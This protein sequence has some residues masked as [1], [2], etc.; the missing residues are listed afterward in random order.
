[1]TKSSR[2]IVTANTETNEYSFPIPNHSAQLESRFG[3]ID[4]VCFTLHILLTDYQSCRE[5]QSYNSSMCFYTQPVQGQ[6]WSGEAYLP[7]MVGYKL[8][9]KTP[10]GLS[11]GKLLILMETTVETVQNFQTKLYRDIEFAE[12]HI[13]K[14]ERK[15]SLLVLSLSFAIGCLCLLMCTWLMLRIRREP[16]PAGQDVVEDRPAAPRQNRDRNVR[17]A[18]DPAP[19]NEEIELMPINRN[20][21]RRR[22]RRRGQANAGRQEHRR[23]DSRNRRSNSNSEEWVSGS[24]DDVPAAP[25]PARPEAVVADRP[26]EMGYFA[27]L[28]HNAAIEAMAVRR[29]LRDPPPIFHP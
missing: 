24:D 5:T 23:K 13:L 16:Q 4:S 11:N 10:L 3:Q 6:S 25:A 27:R 1:M 28:R 26:R 2:R 15:V 9:V 17:R 12:L 20:A 8:T 7:R 18:N 22:E 29:V 14:E 21:A 19:N